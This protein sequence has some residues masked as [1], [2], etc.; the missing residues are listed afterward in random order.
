MKMQIGELCKMCGVTK[1]AVEYYCK[2]GLL[3]PAVH[4]NGYRAFKNDD[5]IRLNKIA[6]LRS[7]DVPVNEILTIL[8]SQN[9]TDTI[10]MWIE[11]EKFKK[12]TEFEKYKCLCDLAQTGNWDK[13]QKQLAQIENKEAVFKRLQYVFP[14][15][16]G[17]YLCL[18]FGPYL[19][20]PVQTPKQKEA[21]QTIINWLDSVHFELP[22]NLAAYMESMHFSP[23]QQLYQVTSDAINSAIQDTK[24]FIRKHKQEMD[25][26][27][28]LKQSADYQKSPAGQFENALKTFMAESGYNDVFIPAMCDLS[29]EYSIYQQKL[30]SANAQFLQTYSQTE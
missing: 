14:G 27:I 21:F 13:A 20:H 17:N 26:Y 1:K 9:Q 8:N 2:K 18:H 7:L 23:T 25:K 5:V 11:K 30:K 24:Q 16:F 12:E 19:Q 15:S 28:A 10:Q 3:N 29:E 4:N 22:Q 6:A